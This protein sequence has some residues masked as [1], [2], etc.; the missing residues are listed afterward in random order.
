MARAHRR[1]RG[2]GPR[3]R[4]AGCW[5]GR[6]RH[7]VMLARAAPPP[8]T[9]CTH[10]I[11]LVFLEF[12]GICFFVFPLHVLLLLPLVHHNRVPPLFHL[13]NRWLLAAIASLVCRC[14]ACFVGHAATGE[15]EPL[16]R[17]LLVTALFQ[18]KPLL[19]SCGFLVHASSAV[20]TVGV[21]SRSNDWSFCFTIV[22]IVR[23]CI[24]FGTATAPLNFPQQ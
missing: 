19:R 1:V 5:R 8:T 18:Y 22:M 24:N 16:R 6:G 20:R 3:A 17:R 14:S 9:T 4:P 15:G 10:N 23:T 21:T 2:V 7:R 12:P 11:A 13:P